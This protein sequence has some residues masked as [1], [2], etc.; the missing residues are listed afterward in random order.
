[1]K[2][3]QNNTKWKGEIKQTIWSRGHLFKLGFDPEQNLESSKIIVTSIS[4]NKIK[5]IKIKLNW[6]VQCIQ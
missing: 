2:P 1:M 5:K 6:F 3:P 4:S